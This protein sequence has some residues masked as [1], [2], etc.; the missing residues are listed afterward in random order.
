MSSVVLAFDTATPTLGVGV[1][2]GG[3]VHVRVAPGGR[4]CERVLLPLA[5]ELLDVVG[6]AVGDVAAV[7]VA[8]GP[9]AFTGLR[10]GLAT[11]AGLAQGLRVPLVT[12]SSFRGRALRVSEPG[13]GIVMLDARKQ[14]VYAQVWEDGSP[15]GAAGDVSPEA[16]VRELGSGWATGEGAA[17]YRGMLEEAGVAVVAH[18]EAPGVGELAAWVARRWQDG[19]GIDPSHVRPEYLREPDAVKRRQERT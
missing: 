5:Q 4:G 18:P 9:G 16:A 7:G 3:R 14:R 13:R 8:A 19:H 12:A 1:W 2:R 10:V 11:A 6:A 15:V 17:V